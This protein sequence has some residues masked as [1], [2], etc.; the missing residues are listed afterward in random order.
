MDQ[1][2]LTAFED[3]LTKMAGIGD[4]WRKLRQA[5][6]LAPKEPVKTKSDLMVDYHFSPKAGDDKWDKFLRNVRDPKFE[7][8]ISK[9]PESHEKLVQHA[10][11]MHYMARGK[12][13]APWPVLRDQGHP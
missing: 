11:S 12:T 5:F 7:Q 4:L 2:T 1:A 13:V 10:K 6:G 8:A 9:H 3:E